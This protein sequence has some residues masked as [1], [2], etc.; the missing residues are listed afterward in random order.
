MRSLALSASE[1]IVSQ[2][3]SLLHFQ[4]NGY[5]ETDRGQRET[6]LPL[7]FH[8]MLIPLQPQDSLSH[9]VG[10]GEGDVVQRR[11]VAPHGERA[12]LD[13]RAV[14][15]SEVIGEVRRSRR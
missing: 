15:R 7:L 13:Y 12:Q 11:V 8:K 5:P 10:E 6:T 9:L 2:V 1:G 3:F 14:N 4:S